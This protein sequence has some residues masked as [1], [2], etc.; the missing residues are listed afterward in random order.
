MV[1]NTSMAMQDMESLRSELEEAKHC[2]SQLN[3]E[4]LALS[5]MLQVSHR[6][7][8]YECVPADDTQQSCI[9][10]HLRLFCSLVA[11]DRSLRAWWHKLEVGTELPYAM[12]TDTRDNKADSDSAFGLAQSKL[13]CTAF[14]PTWKLAPVN[15]FSVSLTLKSADVFLFF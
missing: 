5:E 3:A 14:T 13:L 9:I 1:T 8:H 12:C 2:A 10:T 4:K 15:L 6:L 11:C 7:A